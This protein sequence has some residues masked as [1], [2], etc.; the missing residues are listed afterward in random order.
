M[1]AYTIDKGNYSTHMEY[2]KVCMNDAIVI[3]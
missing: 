1:V 2:K 3:F